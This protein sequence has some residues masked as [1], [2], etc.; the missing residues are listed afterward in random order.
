MRRRDDVGTPVLQYIAALIERLARRGG[1]TR[2][3]QVAQDHAIN[4]T[5]LANARK[6]RG[7][8]NHAFLGVRVRIAEGGD[9]P[10]TGVVAEP[11]PG[12]AGVHRAVLGAVVVPA[13]AEA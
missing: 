4:V 6:P 13:R 7:V 12:V 5:A 8:K 3:V 9:G 1:P 10:P 2:V 11:V